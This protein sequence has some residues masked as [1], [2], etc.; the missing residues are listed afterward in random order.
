MAFNPEKPTIETQPN[1]ENPAQDLETV[2]EGQPQETFEVLGDLKSQEEKLPTS[3][4]NSKANKLKKALLGLTAGLILFNAS[5]DFARAGEKPTKEGQKTEMKAEEQKSEEIKQLEEEIRT[6][7]EKNAQL[8]TEKRGETKEKFQPKVGNKII[9]IFSG[10][11]DAII[12]EIKDGGI[13]ILTTERKE[14][15]ELRPTDKEG[16]YEFDGGGSK[17]PDGA[18]DISKGKMNFIY[19]YG[20]LDEE[21]EKFSKFSDQKTQTLIQNT[22]FEKRNIKFYEEVKNKLDSMNRVEINK[23]DDYHTQI[24][25]I[26]D[27]GKKA[28]K[29]FDIPEGYSIIKQHKG[30]DGQPETTE[31]EIVPPK[32]GMKRLSGVLC[33]INGDIVL[34]TGILNSR[35]YGDGTLQEALDKLLHQ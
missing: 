7:K 27:Q 31:V 14:R 19:N 10:T 34:H 22:P 11:P 16:I 20:K 3:E 35:S 13:I 5:P 9:H 30:Y 25:L 33:V 4:K 29:T 1:L 21:I 18:I 15:M 26:D 24:T 23:L 6:L 8:E 17:L 2:E 28:T 12:T 32:S